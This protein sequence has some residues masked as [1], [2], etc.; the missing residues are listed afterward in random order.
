MKAN[1][2]ET[3]TTST[4]SNSSTLDMCATAIAQ[5]KAAGLSQSNVN[6]FVSSMEE[7]IFEIQSQAKDVALQ[8]LSPQNTENT[9]KIEQSFQ[10]LENPFTPLNTEAKLNKHLREKWGLIEPV[11]KVLGTRFDSRR[12]KTTGTYDQVIVTD[13][14]A[15]VPMLEYFPK[16]RTCRH[17]QA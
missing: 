7:V 16:T 11:E 10:K 8:C 4:L 3:A 15:Y 1:V 13:R 2:E 14:F 6:T 12:N 9:N 5:L 17:V